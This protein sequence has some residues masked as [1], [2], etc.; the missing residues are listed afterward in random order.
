MS[1]IINGIICVEQ[2]GGNMLHISFECV[3]GRVYLKSVLEVV[4][5]AQLESQ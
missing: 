5:K 1:Y 4:F 3:L 2:N